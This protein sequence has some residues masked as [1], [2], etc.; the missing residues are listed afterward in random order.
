MD[1]LIETLV[2]VASV[3][4]SNAYWVVGLAGLFTVA[5]LF[6]AQ[7][8]NPGKQWWRNGGLI[9][10]LSYCFVIPVIMP[11]V[12]IAALTVAMLVGVPTSWRAVR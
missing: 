9:T 2:R 1:I 5:G 7:A 10:D 8:C 3:L 4:M 6:Q 11:Y 12:R